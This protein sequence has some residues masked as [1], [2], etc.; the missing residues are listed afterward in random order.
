MTLNVDIGPVKAANFKAV[1]VF[2]EGPN[3]DEAGNSKTSSRFELDGDLTMQKWDILSGFLSIDESKPVPFSK[4]G[5][6]L[7]IGSSGCPG[8]TRRWSSR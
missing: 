4:L 1:R 6:P 8:T 3:V 7:P 2:L 5:L